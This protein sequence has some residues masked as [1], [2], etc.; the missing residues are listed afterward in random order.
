MSAIREATADLEERVDANTLAIEA[1][2]AT[3]AT[4]ATISD[5]QTTMARTLE[6][7]A[8]R[9]ATLEDRKRADASPVLE[10]LNG[11]RISDGA[12]GD[13]VDITWSFLKL[14]DDCGRPRVNLYFRNG[15]GRV[16]RFR[17][18][19]AVDAEG[20][21]VGATRAHPSLPQSISYTAVIPDD[22]GVH[23]GRAVAWN[24]LSWPDCPSVAAVTS[25][26]VPFLILGRRAQ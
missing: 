8:K 17:D 26:E 4:L 25:P 3:G 15:G 5:T 22:E 23:P 10:F 7:T 13:T 2:A 21:G 11:S 19:S 9:L 1:L 20:R 24:N 18:I 6:D 16:H 12:P 14:R